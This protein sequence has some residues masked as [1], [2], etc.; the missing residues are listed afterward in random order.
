MA[1]RAGANSGMASAMAEIQKKMATI[2][3]VPVLTVTKMGSPTGQADPR[4]AQARA[5]LEEMQKSGGPGA[6]MATEML[7][8]MG[9]GGALFEVTTESSNFSAGSIAAS[10][11]EIPAGYQKTESAH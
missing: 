5:K 8:K 6:Q 9:G 11:F 1:G 4:M 3:G 2:N 7:A 10:E